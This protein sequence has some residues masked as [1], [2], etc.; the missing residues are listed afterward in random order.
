MSNFSNLGFNI[1]T[2]EEYQ[3]LLG[4]AYKVSTSIQINEGIYS[5]YKD[6][7]G[8]ELYLQFNKQNEFIGVNPH[9]EG[10]S[11]RIVCLT[12]TVDRSESELDGAFYCWAAPSKVNNPDSGAYPFVFDVPDFRTLTKVEFPRNV[13]IQLTAFAQELTIYD[14]EK[15]YE[16]SQTSEF[17]F[18]TQSFIP[19]G[20]F[21]LEEKSDDAVP[22]SF[23]IFTG[24]IRQ[25]EKKCNEMTNEYFY[26]LLV[27]TLGGE[28][29]VVADIR[30]FEKPPIENGILQGQFW[31]SGKIINMPEK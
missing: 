23:G 10:K 31:L 12:G 14:N 15:E 26:W 5:I 24:I 7:S 28:V 13:E 6:N 8:A 19:S 1:T 20:L 11:K 16:D 29:D 17:K 21:S 4:K 2:P 18:A 25:F 3:E 22:Q 27:D 30:F 9:F